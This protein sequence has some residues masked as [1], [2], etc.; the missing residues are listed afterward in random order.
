IQHV[1][2]H[3]I[4][5]M[6]GLRHNFKG[7]LLPPSTSVMD[8]L[9]DLTDAIE[10]PEPQAY[11]RDAIRYLYGLSPELPAQPFCTDEDTRVD[12]NCNL[13]DSQADPLSEWWAPQYFDGASQILG[14][15]LPVEFLDFVGLKQIFGY[16]RDAGAV[17]PEQRLAALEV[18]LAPVQVPFPSQNLEHPLLIET[19]NLAADF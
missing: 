6:L 18:A 13:F 8:Y 7:S 15:G 4:G 9:V 12:P 1:L 16:A 10:V 14:L 11:D 3:E 2:A 17:S 5:H 19:T